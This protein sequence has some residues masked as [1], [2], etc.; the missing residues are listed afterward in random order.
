[1]IIKGARVIDPA[2][3][4][5]ATLDIRIRDGIIADVASGL[6]AL[7]SEEVL[8]AEGL[9]AAPGLVDVHSHFRDPGQTHKE[10]LHTGALAAAAGGYTSVICMAN[11]LP[12]VDNIDTL[13]DIIRRAHDEKIHIYQ[14]AAVTR[15][16]AGESLSDMEALKEAGAAGFTDDGSPIMD[17]SVVTS[18]MK[19]AARIDT[20]L[21]FHEEDPAYVGIAG[22]NEGAA[23]GRLG[24]KGAD[25]KA[26]YSMVERDL[27]LALDTG[28]RIDIQHVSAKES[29]DLIREYKM[30]DR[31]GLIHAEATPHHFSLTEDA[32]SDYGS[33]AKVN[34]PI[35]TEEDRLAIIRGLADGTLDLIATDHAPHAA[36]EKGAALTEAPSGMTGLE[37]A[38][39]LGITNLVKTDMLSLPALI[40]LMS[41]NPARLYGLPAGT[42][43]TGAPADIVLFDRDMEYTLTENILH[44]RSFNTPFIGKTLTGRVMY[45]ISDGQIVFS[46]SSLH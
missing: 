41:L 39:S 17:L 40:S 13:S 3:D 20:I 9:T 12:A 30:K 8:N 31:K 24:I 38:L 34:P 5:D 27:K 23:S 2:N 25:R 37:T 43:S 45:T 28:A 7:D 1:M 4:I 10:T 15:D 35:R 16:R 33:L 42:L 36:S 44:S 29:V 22:I 26:E 19:E 32:I 18:A 11:T 6:T 46:S 14:T 21:S